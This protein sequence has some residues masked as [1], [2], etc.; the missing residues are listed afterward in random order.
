MPP[1]DTRRGALVQAIAEAERGPEAAPQ[2]PSGGLDMIHGMVARLAQRLAA[3]PDDPQG[4]V[5]LVRAYA[6]LGDAAHRDQA[7][8]TARARY[9]GQA[10]LLAQLDAAAH[11]EPMR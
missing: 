11:A 2:A 5:R 1:D 7:L 9:A 4:W 6:V 3:N 10:D 8:A